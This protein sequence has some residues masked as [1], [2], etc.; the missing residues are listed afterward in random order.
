MADKKEG[1]A[2]AAPSS[3]TEQRPTY[4]YDRTKAGVDMGGDGSG[5]GDLDKVM[6]ANAEKG[7]AGVTRDEADHSVAGQKRG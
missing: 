3:K 5:A 1:A 4:K 2:T 7:Y 6:A